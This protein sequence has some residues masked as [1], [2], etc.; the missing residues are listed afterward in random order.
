MKFELL[1]D[2]SRAGK[3]V[4]DLLRRE[5]GLSNRMMT[6]LKQ[7]EQGILVDGER[8]TVRYQ[9]T[10]GQRLTLAVDDRVPAAGILPVNLPLELLA[11]DADFFAVNKPPAMPTHP[12]HGH[13]TD[14]LANALA[15]HCAV[16]GEPFVFR[17]VNRLDRN[18]SGVVLVARNQLAA[19]RLAASMQAGEIE[20]RYLAL[21]DGDLAPDRGKI[22]APIRRTADSII[23]RQV[24]ADGEGDFA[25]TRWRVMARGRGHTLVEAVPVTGRTHQLRVHFA[26]LGCSIHGD[27]LYGRAADDIARQ[28]LHAFSLDFPHPADRRPVHVTAPPPDDLRDCITAYF[29]KDC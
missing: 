24:C 21:L 2:E 9:L 29:G 4:F 7:D 20:K 15:Y 13:Y 11:E 28:A 14:T 12:S 10:A 16:V 3:R 1:I 18:T 17:P 8:V 26:Y 27:D 22:C 5:L 25:L 19:G 23:T 6:R